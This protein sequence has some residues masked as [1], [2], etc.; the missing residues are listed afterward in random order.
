MLKTLHLII[1][2]LLLTTT[3]ACTNTR[4]LFDT[5]SYTEKLSSLY[6]SEDGDN[7][8]V[9]TDSYHYIFKMPDALLTAL[10]SDYA[11]VLSARFNQFHVAKDSSISGE[12]ELMVSVSRA[13]QQ[14]LDFAYNNGFTQTHKYW[15]TNK[16][17]L[18]GMRYQ[19][20]GINPVLSEQQLNGNYNI[21]ITEDRTVGGTLLIIPKTPVTILEDVVQIG[22]GAL[23]LVVMTLS[24]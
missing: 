24:G 15:L 1:L 10:G 20:D 18:H 21:K 3:T 11:K 16:I 4:A 7:F 19:S 17:K 23:V 8:I 5:P 2:T 14:Q 6:M 22:T 9:F 13:S 12:V